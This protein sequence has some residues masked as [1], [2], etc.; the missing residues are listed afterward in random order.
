[1]DQNQTEDK[2]PAFGNQAENLAWGIEL[3]SICFDA[4]Q[5]N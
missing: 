5:W 2:A 4:L 1:M 3:L